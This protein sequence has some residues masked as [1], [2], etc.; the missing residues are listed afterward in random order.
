MRVAFVGCGFVADYYVR[1]FIA[2]PKLQIAGVADQNPERLVKFARHHSVHIFH[3]LE[4][5]LADPSVDI[6]VNLT[7]PRSHF[8]ISQ[9][10]LLAG[11]HVYSEKPLAMNF[12]DAKALV[13]LAEQNGLLICSAPC[14]VLGEA[15]QTMWKVLRTKSIGSVRVVYAEL[16]DGPIHRMPYNQWISETGAS[17]PYKD[18]FEVGC[19]LEHAGYYL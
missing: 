4:E 2:H 19:T 12:A 7:N 8:E 17:W 3:S 15:A 16:D 13:E 5:I 6:V 11:K 18:E 9:R 14:N 10:A 1:T